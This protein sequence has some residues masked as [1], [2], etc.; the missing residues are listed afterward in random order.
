M[1][2]RTLSYKC[3]LLGS[4]IDLP[5]PPVTNADICDFLS[6]MGVDGSGKMKAVTRLL[7]MKTRHSSRARSANLEYP[8]D[9]DTNPE[10]VARALTEATVEAGLQVNDLDYVIGH[11]ATPHTLLPPNISWAADILQYTGLYT[12]LRQGCCGFASALQIGCAM[13]NLPEFSA[14]GIVGSEIGTVFFDPR[15]VEQDEEQLVNL[16]QM[17]DGAGAVV[18]GRRDESSGLTLE[19]PFFGRI[20]TSSKPGFCMKTGGSGVP[21][22]GESER[23]LEFEHDFALVQEAG[24]VLLERGLIAAREAGIEIEKV[25]WI[26]PQQANGRLADVLSERLGIPSKKFF[27]NAQVVGNTGSAAM[28]IAFHQLRI[29]GELRDGDTVLTLGAEASKH[30]YGG[31]LYRH[32]T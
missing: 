10:V 32:A 23:L 6:R 28:W 2:H 15:S 12:E 4:G 29:S 1:T 18:I 3:R 13:L 26:I 27:V 25:T 11:T 8:R 7:G 30:M 20:E 31:F 16:A 9:G 21:F 19:S 14:I 22:L 24:P 5:G 17:G